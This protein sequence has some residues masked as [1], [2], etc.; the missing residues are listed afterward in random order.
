VLAAMRILTRYI[1][2]EMVIAFTVIL[3]S[4]TVF[5]FLGLIGKEAVEN[6]LGLHPILRMLP[7]ILPQA[8]QFAVPGAL[9][10]TTTSIYG[11]VASSNE[12]VAIKSLGISPMVMIWPTMILATVVSLGA[13]VL[14]DVAVSWGR[15]GVDRVI[16]ESL[17][18]I[19]YGSLQAK[20]SFSTD[21]LTV[22][23]KRVE[24]R[25][26]IRPT[27]QVESSG[28]Q[29]PS[30][31]TA[32][33]AELRADPT[34]GSVSIKL[35]NTD[36]NFNGWAITHPGEFE[37]SFSMEEFTGQNRGSRHPTSFALSEL[38]AAKSEQTKYIARLH[39]EMA[40]DASAA[41]LFGRMG[42]L[43]LSQWSA[44]ENEVVDS[45][46]YQ[47]RLFT[48]PYRRWANG[49]S[50]LGFALIGAP[51]AIRRRHGEFWGSFFAC[52][53]PILLVYYPMLVGCLSGAKNG[54]L[55]PQ[56]VW[57]GNIALAAWGVWLLR[58]VIRF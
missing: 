17:E 7:Y 1:L 2:I 8:M 52:F 41:L 14:N 6:G 47:H 13:V 19:A 16:L 38:T 46:R 43:S 11:R 10:L 48:E 56:A 32:E 30:L 24:G 27:I 31:I 35:H 28:G 22:H 25:K 5:I 39:G 53:L 54:D 36:G 33:S 18:E 26:L 15:G 44:R 50:C 51:M 42:E 58:R 45:E 3:T 37:R 34:T 20:H 21:K 12:I 4:M 29:P 9:L 49:F 57:L 55:P 23:V 40:A